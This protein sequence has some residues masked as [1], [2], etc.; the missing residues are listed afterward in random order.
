[1]ETKIEYLLYTCIKLKL[2]DRSYRSFWEISVNVMH[3]IFSI[4][5][6]VW[7]KVNEDF[8]RWLNWYFSSK[9]LS[10]NK[11]KVIL[12]YTGDCLA[13]YWCMNG[14]S[15]SSPNDGVTGQLCPAGSYCIQGTPVPTACPLGKRSTLDQTLNAYK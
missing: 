12:F 7:F 10:H 8:F 6:W 3:W 11:F 5:I 4:W 9:F 2:L 1:M 13:R 14:S 15:T